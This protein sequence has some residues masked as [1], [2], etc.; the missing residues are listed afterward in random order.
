MLGVFGLDAPGD[1][2]DMRYSILL[3]KW[4]VLRRHVAAHEKHRW[5]YFAHIA[6][7]WTEQGKGSLH[8]Y[9]FNSQIS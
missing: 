4:Q 9:N 5:D 6:R 1:G 7:N 8:F 3:E 2:H